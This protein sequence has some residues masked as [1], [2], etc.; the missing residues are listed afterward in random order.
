MCFLHLFQQKKRISFGK[1]RPL[2]HQIQFPA[3]AANSHINYF[4]ICIKPDQYFKVPLKSI[5]PYSSIT[6]VSEAIIFKELGFSS[7]ST[8]A[9]SDFVCY[10]KSL[11]I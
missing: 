1:S 6:L 10:I 9:C 3:T 7:D 5:V 11:L 8:P 2:G 4:K